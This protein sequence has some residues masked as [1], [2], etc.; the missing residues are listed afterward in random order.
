MNFTGQILDQDNKPIPGVKVVFD[1]EYAGM[2]GGVY[3]SAIDTESADDGTFKFQAYRGIQ[4]SYNK[5]EK[6]GYY[7]HSW[8]DD[9]HVYVYAPSNG[10]AS[11]PNP[12]KPEIF[13]GWRNNFHH[14]RLHQIKGFS[15]GVPDNGEVVSFYFT[16]GSTRWI[17][18]KKNDADMWITLKTDRG[19]SEMDRTWTCTLEIPD[20]GIQ[21]CTDGF[22]YLA[23]DTG[24]EKSIVFGYGRPRENEA[25]HRESFHL[26]TNDGKVFTILNLRIYPNFHRG[27]YHQDAIFGAS[28]Y[29]NPHG[30][31]NLEPGQPILNP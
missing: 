17:M 16:T 2:T 6:E 15:G 1:Q 24:Y 31:R 26:R 30:S 8:T 9:P 21:K 4:I 10:P 14:E 3:R 7:F 22:G 19:A 27:D 20:G 11:A 25:Y 13:R 29:V 12:S 5:F 18:S 23:P 28:G